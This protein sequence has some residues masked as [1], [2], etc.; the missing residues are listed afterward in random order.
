MVE[1]DFFHRFLMKVPGV[2]DFFVCLEAADFCLVE[3]SRSDNH[4]LLKEDLT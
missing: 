3:N 2:E 4:D 1:M